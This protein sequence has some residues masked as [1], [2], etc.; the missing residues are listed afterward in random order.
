MSMLMLTRITT[1]DP[2][3]HTEEAAF[4]NQN[5]NTTRSELPPH[6][7]E[8]ILKVVLKAPACLDY[9]KRLVGLPLIQRPGFL[10]LF[11]AVFDGT[12]IVTVVSIESFLPL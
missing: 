8:C 4:K 6:H 9:L 11:L 3:F 5:E 12:K 7:L 10:G 1:R 2:P